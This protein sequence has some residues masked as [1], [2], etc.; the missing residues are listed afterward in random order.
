MTNNNPQAVPSRAKVVL[1]VA[2][3]LVVYA[4][5]MIGVGCVVFKL[6]Q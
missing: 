1:V 2:S 6:S 3:M 5:L 4:V